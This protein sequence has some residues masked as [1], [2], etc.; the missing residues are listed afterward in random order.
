MAIKRQ[1]KNWLKMAGLVLLGAI[2]SV[3]I[4]DSITNISPK[5]GDMMDKA[6]A[7]LN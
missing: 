6:E 7:S 2:F 4:K 3:K 5:A 1:T